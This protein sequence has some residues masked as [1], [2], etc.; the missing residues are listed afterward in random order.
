MFDV[1]PFRGAFKLRHD[2]LQFPQ[3]SRGLGFGEPADRDRFQ[4]LQNGKD[5][6]EV[7]DGDRRH[8]RSRVR[9]NFNQAIRLQQLQRLPH[10]DD[11]QAKFPGEIIDDQPLSGL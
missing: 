2:F 3:H 7:L 9:P 1:G 8:R 11:A 4:P 6:V 5:F 10:R